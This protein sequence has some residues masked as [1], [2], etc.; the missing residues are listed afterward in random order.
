MT[1]LPDKAANRKEQKQHGADQTV[2]VT[3]S[4]MLSVIQTEI[5]HKRFIHQ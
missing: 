5:K 4:G 1:V 2:T 3:F